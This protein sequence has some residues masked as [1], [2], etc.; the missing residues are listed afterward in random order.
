MDYAST[1]KASVPHLVRT[2]AEP[3]QNRLYTVRLS[4]VDEVNPT[5]RLIQ[6][7]IPPHVQS[8]EGQAERDD[9]EVCHPP[10]LGYVH[11]N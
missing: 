10:F 7:T 6:L 8:L 2:A 9:G 5:V 3:R 4:H 1:K 11:R